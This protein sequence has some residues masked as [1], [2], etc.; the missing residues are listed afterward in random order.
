ME[1]Q[2]INAEDKCFDLT[3][4]FIYNRLL[5]ESEVFIALKAGEQM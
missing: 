5:Y 3:D 1:Q 4:F 2:K